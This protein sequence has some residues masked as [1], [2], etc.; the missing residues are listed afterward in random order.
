S[1]GFK[2]T[3]V[4]AA[5]GV[6]QPLA[7]ML[8]M[9]QRIKTLALHDKVSIKGM[10]V[11]LSHICTPTNVE[12]YEEKDL[13]KALKN[14][15]IVVVAAG[16]PQRPSVKYEEQLKANAK[17]VVEITKEICNVC[18][19]AL[20]AFITT[21][22][23]AIVPIVAKV[24]MEQDAYDPKRLFGV[25]TLNVVRAKTFIGDSIGV[26]PMEVSIP[27]VGG[28]GETALALISQSKPP[29][30]GSA[31]ERVE[32]LQQMQNA[33]PQVI[34]SK[35]GKG[36]IT[37]SMAYA[38]ASFVNSLLRG[39]NNEKNVI[40]CAYVQSDV[41]E[42]QFFASPVLLGPKG[43]QEN[44]GLPDLDEEEEEAMEELVKKLQKDIDQGLKL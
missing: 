10:A 14:A 2:V 9:N 18:P 37:S 26:D 1:Q 16:Q 22:V 44:L 40:E 7:L 38:S 29:F 28:H 17:V 8:K 13:G 39:L 25:T 23:N 21:P 36:T 31:M 6:G 12:A 35:E 43:I 30:D 20:L 15:S 42:A 11:D 27:V 34:E 4:G 32:V 41:T 33:G 5:G 19:H 24:M 3:L